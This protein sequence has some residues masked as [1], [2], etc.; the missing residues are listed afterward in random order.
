VPG[1]LATTIDVDDLSAIGRTLRILGALSG[2][3]GTNMLKQN[4]GIRSDSMNY[5]FVNSSLKRKPLKV[6]HKIGIQS[7]G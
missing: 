3:L 5:L 7:C 2:G 1:N 4:A 6:G